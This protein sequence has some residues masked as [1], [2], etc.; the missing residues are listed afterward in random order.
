MLC[1]RVTMKKEKR[2]LI[3][4]SEKMKGLQFGSIFPRLTGA[5]DNGQGGNKI[6]T[7]G[8]DRR[9]NMEKSK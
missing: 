1:E 2:C 6:Q 5:L 4:I 3:S 8:N 9:E 7:F